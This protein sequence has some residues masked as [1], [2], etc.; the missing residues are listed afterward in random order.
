MQQLLKS[1]P[2]EWLS[3]LIWPIIFLLWQQPFTHYSNAP[4]WTL[5]LALVV[6]F[7]LSTRATWQVWVWWGLGAVTFFWSL[8]PGSTFN[9]TLWEILYVAAFAAGV[10]SSRQFANSFAGLGFWCFTAVLFVSSLAQALALNAAGLG[11]VYFS[12]S[13]HYMLGAQALMLVIPLF[14]LLLRNPGKWM[15]F[16]W[17]ATIAAVF[18]LLIS[19]ARAVYLPFVVLLLWS[20]WRAW[21]EGVKPAR[22]LMVVGMLVVTVGAIDVAIPFHPVQ[23]ALV[24]KASASLA[25]Q[26]TQEGGSFSSRVQ[27]WDQT[28]G[29]A[30]KY[31]FGTGTA[32]FKDVLPAFQKYPTVLF[33]NAHNYYIETAATGGW[34]RLIVLLG[35]LALTFW[36]ALQSSF[37]PVA[38]GA[39]GL[40]TTFA[41]DITGYFPSMMMLAFAGL[42]LLWGSTQPTSS[43]PK[44]FRSE[45]A[46][47][48]ALLVVMAGM[49][50]WWFAPCDGSR[51]EVD[52][53]FSRSNEVIS[54]L[55]GTADSNQRNSILD[56]AQKVNPKS[57]W[58][59][60]TR[61]FFTD[62]PTKKLEVLQEMNLLFPL[63]HPDTYLEWAKVAVQVGDKAEAI[64][65]L[66]L[67][68]Q[69]FP[70]NLQPAGVPLA[71]A[72]WYADWLTEA[73]K[74]LS[75]LE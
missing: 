69:R 65:A 45:V 5:V 14:V 49:T 64:R 9:A 22:V 34:L 26:G 4:L 75:E 25:I 67:G 15:L 28:L 44:W 38:L 48:V 43:V 50:A 10:A 51:C 66:Q 52:R 23:S 57:A 6:L 54:L 21:R 12:G 71:K 73:Q 41:F 59:W 1:L 31:P 56:V 13:L 74:M 46:G 16:I 24:G 61:L 72:N 35:L 53:H 70:P 55:R 29:M 33:A 7:G 20:T 8:T 63:V 19:G 39:A 40:W 62:L 27:M 58:V 37:W 32:S 60:Q 2:L 42:G 11:L 18:A 68:L 3:W 47:Q 17:I 30:F 36:R